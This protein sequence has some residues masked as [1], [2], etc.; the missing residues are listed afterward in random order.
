MIKRKERRKQVVDLHAWPPWRPSGLEYGRGF[1]VRRG[2][3]VICDDTYMTPVGRLG[4]Q[5]RL[6][7]SKKTARHL[8]GNDFI[9]H[10]K[11]NSLS[12][13]CHQQICRFQSLQVHSNAFHEWILFWNDMQ[14]IVIGWDFLMALQVDDEARQIGINWSEDHGERFPSKCSLTF[15]HPQEKDFK[16]KWLSSRQTTQQLKPQT[17]SYRPATHKMSFC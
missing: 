1:R 17:C 9:T 8:L 12:K 10:T 4:L 3:G 6:P 13:I 5:P 11:K 15:T 16:T 2:L 14:Q 7:R